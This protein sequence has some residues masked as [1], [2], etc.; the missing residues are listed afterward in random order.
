MKQFKDALAKDIYGITLTEA[1]EKGVCVCCK[2]SMY[3]M[4]PLSDID[5]R[6]WKISGLC[7]EC[8]PAE[9]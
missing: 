7:P 4:E 3:D 5:F 2:K 8:F 6:E 9:E 1:H